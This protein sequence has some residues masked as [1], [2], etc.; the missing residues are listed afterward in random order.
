MAPEPV[1]EVHPDTA[2]QYGLSEGARV[3][4]RTMYGSV[5]M[6]ARLTERIRP[7][8]IHIPQ[9]WE[10]ANANVLTGMNAADPISGFPNLKS[11]K[12]HLA[13]VD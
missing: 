1:C 13:G 7:D 8:T 9:G 12:C 11:L 4:V 6:G 10:E 2:F 3:E 5:R